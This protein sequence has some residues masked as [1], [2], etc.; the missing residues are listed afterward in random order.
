MESPLERLRKDVATYGRLADEFGRLA[1]EYEAA[2]HATPPDLDKAN[3]LKAEKIDPM[4]AEIDV[5]RERINA[6]QDEL[7]KA[8]DQ[9]VAAL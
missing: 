7:S 2:V 5:L 1:E 8:R 4:R 6:Q 9:A 3:R